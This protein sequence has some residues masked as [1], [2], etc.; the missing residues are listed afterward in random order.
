MKVLVKNVQKYNLFDDADEKTVKQK[1][2]FEANTQ[3]NPLNA[4]RVRPM[5]KASMASIKKD[6]INALQYSDDA[7]YFDYSTDAGKANIKKLEKYILSLN[8]PR[9]EQAKKKIVNNIINNGVDRIANSSSKNTNQIVTK[10]YNGVIKKS[11]KTFQDDISKKKLMKFIKTQIPKLQYKNDSDIGD[12]VDDIINNH[13]NTIINQQTGDKKQISLKLFNYVVTNNT[14]TNISFEN[15]DKGT[16]NKKALK[17][18]INSIN[19]IEFLTTDDLIKKEGDKIIADLENVLK[20][21]PTQY[22]SL[23]ETEYDKIQNNIKKPLGKLCKQ[24]SDR[25]NNDNDGVLKKPIDITQYVDDELTNAKQQIVEKLNKDIKQIID[26]EKIKNNKD[27]GKEVISMLR[28][29]IYNHLKL[30]LTDEQIINDS[31]KKTPELS[32]EVVKGVF[33]QLVEGLYGIIFGTSSKISD[34]FDLSGANTEESIDKNW[35]DLK[36]IVNAQSSKSNSDMDDIFILFFKKSIEII[37][38]DTSNQKLNYKKMLLS[39]YNKYNSAFSLTRMTNKLSRVDNE[40]ISNKL[41]DKNTNEY[42]ELIKPINSDDGIKNVSQEILKSIF[43][44]DIYESFI[45]LYEEAKKLDRT[46]KKVLFNA[47]D[48]LQKYKDICHNQMKKNYNDIDNM[49]DINSIKKLITELSNKEF[50]K[51]YS[52]YSRID[53]IM[54]MMKRYAVDNLGFFDKLGKGKLLNTKNKTSILKEF[55]KLMGREPSEKDIELYDR[56]LSTLQ[57]KKNDMKTIYKKIPEYTKKYYIYRFVH[58]VFSIRWTFIPFE[59]K[60]YAKLDESHDENKFINQFYAY[61]YL[62]KLLKKNDL[63]PTFKRLLNKI[64]ENK[65]IVNERDI[66]P[67][68]YDL[69]I[70]SNRVSIYQLRTAISKIP[71]FKTLYDIDYENTANEMFD[72]Q[73]M[74]ITTKK[75][76]QFVGLIIIKNYNDLFKK[77]ENK[78]KN[79]SNKSLSGKRLV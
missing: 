37:D 36:K 55:V 65:Y 14:N 27:V 4:T 59:L 19:D 12:L 1:C 2:I 35:E 46:D 18:Y 74:I 33:I 39:N 76:K 58:Y 29:S 79:A 45:P 60:E 13:L 16:K 25:V 56:F 77:I 40:F 78:I 10:V 28:K 75:D 11:P 5:S 57:D 54:G 50:I 51:V 34:V 7:Q 49:S 6:V 52:S 43:K 66:L 72:E 68:I 67:L 71:D 21:A 70:I 47:I 30:K 38:N 62:S 8:E 44:S 15:D 9:N 24:I 17:L 31:A 32:K 20:S 61:V 23:L 63:S 3:N 22:D 41:L 53:P 73:P 69:S 42:K 48:V 64:F 26:T